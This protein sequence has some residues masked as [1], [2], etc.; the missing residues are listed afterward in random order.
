VSGIRPGDTVTL[1]YRLSCAGQEVVSTFDAAPETFTLGAGDI[2]PRLEWLLHGLESGARETW[3]LDPEQA[4]GTRNPDLVKTLPRRDFPGGMEPVVG[5]EAAFP[6]P[7]G[8][9]FT[10]TILDADDTSVQLD[11]NHP[12]A[13][14]PV[15]FE[16]RILA[17]EH[18]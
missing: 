16:V 14:L 1:H 2:D 12:L 5:H 10:G 7:N 17:V 8:Q 13:G 15:E 3:R 11:F 6:M 4:F 18:P 9:V